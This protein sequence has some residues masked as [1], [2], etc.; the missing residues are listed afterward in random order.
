M[1]KQ[2]KRTRIK[3]LPPK[4]QLDQ[5]D[6]ATGSLPT[7]VRLSSDNRTGAYGAGWNDK[8]TVIFSPQ[9][10]SVGFTDSL[11]A[12]YKFAKKNLVNNLPKDTTGPLTLEFKPVFVGNTIT[13]SVEDGIFNFT[14]EQNVRAEPLVFGNVK[15]FNAFGKLDANFEYLDDI[16]NDVSAKFSLPMS[17]G[18][19]FD[20]DAP[21][22]YS[23]WFK[24]NDISNLGPMDAHP[25]IAKYSKNGGAFELLLNAQLQL[26]ARIYT[27]DNSFANYL[28]TVT[29]PTTPPVLLGAWV[30]ICVVYDKKFSII[31]VNGEEVP[32]NQTSVGQGNSPVDNP[33]YPIVFNTDANLNGGA[34]LNCSFNEVAFFNRE[35]TSAEIRAVYSCKSS[36]LL[37][38]I[39]GVAYPLGLSVNSHWIEDEEQ[40]TSL[41][42]PFGNVVKGVGDKA[43][44]FSPGQDLEPFRDHGRPAVDGKSIYSPF[45]AT[46][47][48]VTAAGEGFDQPLW[49]KSIIEFDFNI[50]QSAAVGYRSGSLEGDDYAMMYF[51]AGS[52]TFSGVGSNRKWDYYEEYFEDLV[53]YTPSDEASKLTIGEYL[54]DK[55]IGF[56]PFIPVSASAA[57]TWSAGDSFRAQRPF[58]AAGFPRSGKY[59]VHPT[60]SI[61]LPLKE[62]I[63]RPFLLEKIVVDFSGSHVSRDFWS[64]SF[65]ADKGAAINT[66]F[67]LNQSQIRPPFSGSLGVRNNVPTVGNYDELNPINLS[68]SLDLV[69]FNQ[70]AFLGYKESDVTGELRTEEIASL[71]QREIPFWFADTEASMSIVNTFTF[72]PQR[73][74]VEGKAQTALGSDKFLY[75]VPTDINADRLNLEYLSIEPGWGGGRNGYNAMG[76]P[77]ARSF[78]R[79]MTG[80]SSISNFAGELQ[81]ENSV[82]NIQA[83]TPYILQPSD[84]LIFGFQCAYINKAQEIGDVFSEDYIN[85]GPTLTVHPGSFRVYLYGSYVSDGTETHDTLN[86]LLTS[87]AIHEV[88]E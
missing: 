20:K 87:V 52:G 66:F 37:N 2:N 50:V 7:T 84:N 58:S 57:A 11:V 78:L 39:A 72:E 9:S 35:L 26:E 62:R 64:D 70:F 45:Y 76:Y 86:Q 60:S 36:L 54:K 69:S 6:F 19:S 1:S 12:Y 48:T 67:I 41:I 15:D 65:S 82:T 47:S 88:I 5:K 23:F 63:D 75:G 49:S 4:L 8:N 56:E 46:G 33:D 80:L 29:T 22:T 3:G 73:F 71:R 85:Q 18:F 44:H 40:T 61:L 59:A 51:D 38:D 53:V 16:I 31:F 32:Q 21:G 74:R 13:G 14:Y 17:R 42:L 30:H 28:R 43:A 55:A 77:D 10:S 25:I 81:L 34:Y 27:Q 68:A 24:A 79:H 83:P